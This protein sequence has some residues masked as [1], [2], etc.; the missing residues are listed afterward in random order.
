MTL[1]GAGRVS[2]GP[3]PAQC[4]TRHAPVCALST[5]SHRNAGWVPGIPTRTMAMPALKRTSASRRAWHRS[6]RA[7]WFVRSVFLATL[8]C[9]PNRPR[10]ALAET[11][12]G[13]AGVV[14]DETKLGG[15]THGDGRVLSGIE[16]S[17]ERLVP[18]RNPTTG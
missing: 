8:S 15:R 4:Q 14:L 10:A 9:H 6:H 1:C 7:A 12:A 2:G 3:V 17:E 18:G 13:A 11:G 16:F 5:D